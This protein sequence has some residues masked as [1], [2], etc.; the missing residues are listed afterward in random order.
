MYNIWNYDYI[1]QHAQQHHQNQ[2]FQVADTARKLQEFL[3]SADKVE[4]SY[5]AALTT[6][7]CLV[8][9]NY[10]HKHGLI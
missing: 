1:Q 10:A 7:C 5:K 2:I 4:E 3:D 9:L 8:L 6:E